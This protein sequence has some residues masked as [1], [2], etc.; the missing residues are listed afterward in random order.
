MQSAFGGM[1]TAT[2]ERQRIGGMD[3]WRYWCMETTTT[4]RQLLI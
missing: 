4:E 1:E 2:T 3:V